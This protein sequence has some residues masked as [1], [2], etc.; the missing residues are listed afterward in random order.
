MLVRLLPNDIESGW[1]KISKALKESV[2][3]HVNTDDIGM[4]NLLYALLDDK[5][6][7]WLVADTDFNEEG[8]TGIVTTLTVIDPPSG[9]RNLLIYSLAAFRPLSQELINDGYETLKNYAEAKGCFKII[10]YTNIPR[11]EEMVK[12]L[13]GKIGHTLV[14]LEI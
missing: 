11:I 1:D 5:L 12:S 13:G 10:A 4:S 2:P 8:M 3:E 9:T 6:Q 14:E 7:C